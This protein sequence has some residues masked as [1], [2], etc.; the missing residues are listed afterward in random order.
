MCIFIINLNHILG[1]ALVLVA[2]VFG[3]SVEMVSLEIPG[4]AMFP[5]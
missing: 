4:E 5:S 2:M 1:S 3:S